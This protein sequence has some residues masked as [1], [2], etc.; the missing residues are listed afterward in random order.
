M[1]GTRKVVGLILTVLV[2]AI[3]GVALWRE[4]PP[5]PTPAGP[6]KAEAPGP[7]SRPGVSR[8]PSE[9]APAPPA[10]AAPLPVAWTGGDVELGCTVPDLIG[11]GFG[12][13]KGSDGH[14]S[15]APYES[16]VF[17][18]RVASRTGSGIFRLAVDGEWEVS[19]R[20]EGGVVRC[21]VA[22]TA[23]T[24]GLQGRAL[25]WEAWPSDTVAVVRGCEGLAD[26]EPDGTFFLQRRDPE[27]CALQVYLRAEGKLAVAGPFPL[28]EPTGEVDTM[29][30]IRVP[31]P[32]ELRRLTEAQ[33]A[34]LE[35]KVESLQSYC[36]P[37]D[38]CYDTLRYETRQLEIHR[39][40]RAED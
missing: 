32:S 37:E 2:L 39:A 36:G 7:A 3:G 26:I 38:A 19:W 22:P 21:E 20:D 13:L 1:P 4:R 25:G 40:G 11:T 8:P 5:A 18:A 27:P 14:R 30:D 17:R 9:P 16:G 29:L 33:A 10:S 34:D 23:P 24:W 28:A 35:R 12:L 31:P 6:Y 15:G